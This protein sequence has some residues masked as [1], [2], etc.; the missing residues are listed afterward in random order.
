[1]FN[2]VIY[3]SK[4]KS[5]YRPVKRDSRKFQLVAVARFLKVNHSNLRNPVS[6]I[7]Y[8]STLSTWFFLYKPNWFPS[9]GK[10]T[11][12]ESTLSV[13]CSRNDK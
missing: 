6:L 11:K 1:M 4:D 2:D 5:L 9:D 10:R 12:N 7:K 3:K 13:L 8:E